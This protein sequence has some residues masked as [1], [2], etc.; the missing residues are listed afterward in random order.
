MLWIESLMCVI[1][2]NSREKKKKK[3]EGD[4]DTLIS[5]GADENLNILPNGSG[6]SAQTAQAMANIT[7]RDINMELLI[8]LLKHIKNK[9]L[10]G[11]ILI[12]LPGWNV[13]FTIMKFLQQHPIFGKWRVPGLKF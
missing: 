2:L 3:E 6:Y 7:E 10:N 5:S 12:F 13:I 8:D 11:A 1:Y 9:N 4:E